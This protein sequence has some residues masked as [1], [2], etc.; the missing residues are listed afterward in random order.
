M[1]E[2]GPR[3]GGCRASWTRRRSS[4]A[5]WTTPGDRAGA[6]SWGLTTKGRLFFTLKLVRG[7]DLRAIFEHVCAKARGGLEPDARARRAAPGVRRRCRSRYERGVIHR[8]L[9]PANVMV[10]PLRRV[11][12]DG[13]GTGAS[14]G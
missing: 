5:G 7:R 6:S 9:K 10:G 2:I 12:R 13:L 1:D 4:P 11:V 3:C 14:L 8:D